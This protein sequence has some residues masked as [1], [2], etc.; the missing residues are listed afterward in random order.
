MQVCCAIDSAPPTQ[1]PQ[2]QPPVPVGGGLQASDLPAPGYC[3]NHLADRIVGGE[4]TQISEYPWMALL[5]YTKRNINMFQNLYS[6]K[7]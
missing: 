1:P 4:E 3:G 6:K 7:I 2:T 5:E